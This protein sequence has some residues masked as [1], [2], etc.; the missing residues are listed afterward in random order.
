MTI[1]CK[2]QGGFGNHLLN[3]FLGIIYYEHLNTPIY[4]EGNAIRN[5]TLHLRN[6][7]RTTIYKVINPT[8]VTTHVENR[9]N[10][11]TITSFSSYLTVLEN[12][13]SYKSYNI[14]IHI[15]CA[16]KMSF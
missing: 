10:T 12:I 1:I 15:I 7:T 13:H 2:L 8:I 9:P 14:H 16:D 3:V 5:D 4:L 6:D 11:I